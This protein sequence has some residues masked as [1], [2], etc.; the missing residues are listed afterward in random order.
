MPQNWQYQVKKLI[1]DKKLHRRWLSVLLLLSICVSLATT[2]LLIHPSLTLT[3][4]APHCCCPYALHR[5]TDACYGA[6]GTLQC[7]YAV[8][9]THSALCYDTAGQLICTLPELAGHTHGEEC[10]T[11]ERVLV[12]PLEESAG[13]VHSDFCYARARTNLICEIDDPEH[14][15]GDDCYAWDYV[16]SCGLEEGAGAHTHSDDCYE[17]V[18]TLTCTQAEL[19]VHVHTEDCFTY[20]IE[21]AETGDPN[22]DVETAAVWERTLENV[23]LQQRWREDLVAVAESQLG[24]TESKRNFVTVDGVRKGWTR[25][26]AWY[27]DP[28]GDWCAMFLSFC[29][30]Y[31]GIPAEDMPQEASC[32][33][34]LQRMIEL[35][36]YRPVLPNDETPYEP[37]PGDLVFFRMNCR[38]G[39]DHVGLFVGV[40]PETGEL[41]TIEGNSDNCVQTLRYA[42]DDLRIIGYAELP[43]QPAETVLEQRYTANDGSVYAVTV[44]CGPDA[45]VP[46]EASL[47]VSEPDASEYY[48]YLMQT[49]DA[50]DCAAWSLGELRLLDISIELDGEELQP[51]SAVSVTIRPETAIPQ[52]DTQVVHFGDEAELVDTE[53]VDGEIRFEAE[54]FSV[55]AIVGSTIEQTVLAS[56]GNNY[57]ITVTCGEDS[58][59]PDGAAL[60]VTEIADGSQQYADYLAMSESALGWNAGSAACVKM[61]DIK[62]L[63]ALGQ[64]VEIAAPVDVQI[65]LVGSA[66][67]ADTQ[68]VHIADGAAAADVVGSVAIDGETVSF[69]ASGF[70]AYAIVNA[71]SIEETGGWE[72]LS[73]MSDLE[74]HIQNGDGIYIGHVDGYYATSSVTRVNSSRNG[75]SKTEP[76]QL[77][78]PM[79]GAVPYFFETVDAAN[80]QYKI[81]CMNGANRKYVQQS[82]N[83]L[84][85]VNSVNSASVFTIED[86]G[87]GEDTNV[88]R[89]RGANNYCWNMQGGTSGHC[90]AAY[91]NLNDV[92]ARFNFWYFTPPTDDP[93][94][95]DGKTYGLMFFNNGLT[96][97]AMMSNESVQ[98]ALE[99][100]SMTVLANQNDREDLLFTPKNSGITRWT[101]HNVESDIYRITAQVNGET[102]YLRIDTNDGVTLV[103]ANEIDAGCNIEIVEGGVGREGQ[104]FLRSASNAVLTY[105]GATN[106]GFFVGGTVGSEWMR[107]VDETDLTPDYYMVH[108][109]DKVSISD[110]EAVPDGSKVIV[111]ARVWDAQ[112]KRYN[113]YAV[114]SD[115]SLIP[116]YESGDQIQWFGDR[117]NTLLWD[118]TEYYWEGT[119]DP[120]GY[121]ELYNEFSGKYI[122]PQL[123]SNQILAD[124][125]IGINLNGRTNGYYY[126]NILAWDDPSYAYAGVQ[127]NISGNSDTI[128]PCTIN[129][130]TDFYFALVHNLPTDDVLTEVPTVDNNLYGITMKMVDFGGKTYKDGKNPETTLQQHN[131]IGD[132]TGG[133]VLTANTGL[134][135]N[136]LDANGYPTATIT[137]ASLADLF[138]S[139]SNPPVEVNHLFLQSI[140]DGSGYFEYDS[141]Q[142]FATL[143]KQDNTYDTDFHVYQEL[144]SY[145]GGSSRPSLQ[146]GQFFPYDN[147]EPGNFCTELNPRNLYTATQVELLEGDPRKNER[148]YKVES[149]DYYFGMQ[150]E[151][152]FVQTPSGHDAWGHDIIYEFTGDDDFW[153]YV[154]GELVID[155]GGIHSALAGS[156]NFCTGDVYVN[157]TPNTLY[158]I[159]RQNYIDRYK[160]ANN[161]AEPSQAE[162]D[163]YLIGTA[164]NQYKDGIFEDDGSP[165]HHMIFKDYTSHTMKI[166]YMERGAGASNLHMRFNLASVKAG[167]VQ[168]TK[169]L[170]NVD[171]NDSVDAV[172]PYQILYRLDDG[173]GGTVEHRLTNN[174]A[175]NINVVYKDTTTPVTFDAGYKPD[176]NNPNQLIY[177]P[178]IIDGV[179]Y[180]DVFLI[181]PGETIEIKFPDETIDYRIVECGIDKN[182]FDSV[183]V[184]TSD[185]NEVLTETERNT[186]TS[187]TPRYDYSLDYKDTSERPRVV[188]TN[189]VDD[190]AL[191]SLTIRKRLF[192]EDGVTEIHHDDP[193]F[194]ADSAIFNFRLYFKTEFDSGFTGASLYPYHVKDNHGEYCYWD[195][196]NQC[197]TSLGETDYRSLSA[198]DQQRATFYTSMNGAISKIPVDYDVEIREVLAGTEFRVQERD[199][200]IPDGY[201]LR[202]YT[203]KWGEN[204]PSPASS[205]PSAGIT[206]SLPAD[207]TPD[208]IVEVN[209]IKGWGLRVNKIWNDAEY[210]ESRDP[211]YVA[212]FV[213]S[214][215]T[216]VTIETQEDDGNGGTITT[217]T[218]TVRRL[219]DGV[220]TMYWYLP[221]LESGSSFSD[222]CVREVALTNP[223]VDANGIVTSYSTIDRIDDNETITVQGIQA[224]F[225]SS[226]AF[227]YT[228]LNE[229]GT[230]AQG[231]NVRTDKIT[232]SRPGVM[233]KKVDWDGQPLAGAQFTLT[234]GNATIGPFT[235]DANGFITE[236]LLG[237]N[238]DYVLNEIRAP[239]GYYGIE[240][241]LTL[242]LTNS[243]GVNTLTVTPDANAPQD[244]G[245]YYSV[246][247]S[248]TNGLPELT[249]KNRT[250]TLTVDKQDGETHEPLAGVI[251]TL[252]REVTVNGYTG[253]DFTP[254]NVTGCTML[255]ETTA[256]GGTVT[257]PV[258]I[259]D[260]NGVI[261][262][263]DETLPHGVYYLI[264]KAAL[265]GYLSMG[266]YLHF[267]IGQ[268][269]EITVLTEGREHWLTKTVNQ[270]GDEIV[271]TLAV[272]NVHATTPVTL[273]KVS[274]NNT[275]PGNGE[276]P[277]SGAVFS[278]YTDQACTV[279]MQ[280]N[281]SDQIN[282]TD[283]NGDGIFFSG[284][285]L[286][287]VYYVKEIIAPAGY[288]KLLGP[289]RL[290]VS[291]SG[292]TLTATWVSGNPN[293]GVGTIT[294][295][296]TTG[297]TCTIRNAAGYELPRTGG[298]GVGPLYVLG[299][300]LLFTAACVLWL[301]YRRKRQRDS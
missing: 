9:H 191:R 260:A 240:A 37:Q 258:L 4:P 262:A 1:R 300:M 151:A 202:D 221:H 232:N 136:S 244:I 204:D 179:A 19:P 47:R 122:A 228:A 237:E 283:T 102:K 69:A 33:V 278:I 190:D 160:A 101:F 57:R 144:G 38:T 118:F 233:L 175:L 230:L 245:D 108:T 128:A 264:E 147:I 135:T 299:G 247:Q 98:G 212:V 171:S 49:A 133:A 124:N 243:G 16:L 169:Q 106:I 291:S 192:A 215:T 156:V 91:N 56:D 74:A 229:K 115:G 153:L 288:Q 48:D 269:G 277:L 170:G 119:T 162:L 41:L 180:P 76:P 23:A 159:F 61:F 188:Y 85:F 271:Y 284:G 214:S 263:L 43:E 70:S 125:K 290:E 109:A 281:G 140:L 285:I 295:D 155:L 103:D 168:L 22:A 195:V 268:K 145:D 267:S 132:S 178:M 27:G 116:V 261:P 83:S 246:S 185:D 95:L 254:L 194:G 88:F 198:A 219:D 3:D 205:A 60:S 55:Y 107:L 141:T 65:E 236:A 104:I 201:S 164:E 209:N 218:S 117:F 292:V 21:E 114:D 186:T 36:R 146:H 62:I 226:A 199:Y 266:G 173:N 67:S 84:N 6:D 184:D 99:A 11:T 251:F 265:P 167:T 257:T 75:I 163:A 120:N 217:Y 182:V 161:G 158:A 166:F 282:L 234:L 121:Y 216:P 197:F 77:G 177:D 224:G 181:K 154:D 59:V 213:G 44:V 94:D 289:M 86:F 25:Y 259:S 241:P 252:H 34:W 100:I 231:S 68:V 248:G 206:D 96:G 130:T 223:V 73:S 97:K 279:P 238:A 138:N 287:G 53:T 32:D 123:S 280:L 296:S 72:K 272:P 31:A 29:L 250:Y 298:E 294:G 45:G 270:A 127:A 13:H 87:N 90:F 150:L 46:A 24:Y 253:I 143:K 15:H 208:P 92:N 28:Y 80:H 30:H 210:M 58:G 183:T 89:I 131:V 255:T 26:G 7:E 249:V 157:G 112:N 40:D 52:A 139:P 149:P 176:P 42:P 134:L 189:S 17:T 293:A 78:Q 50:L 66:L 71:P 196:A 286:P 273:Q 152:S 227:T 274:Y 51:S 79:S 222:Y 10:Y 276:T 110:R 172:F 129:Q 242:R 239:Q 113:F 220:T 126:S 5:H 20:A 225:N 148:L 111:Y 174:D 54:G 200:E 39:S 211:I 275:Q 12:C 187:G 93:Y 18:R 203:L 137:Q 63:D 105:S 235:S 14:E 81:Y 82:S 165:Q 297:F 301:L 35:E 2:A 8:A 193:I 64:K 142:N 256:G 207:S